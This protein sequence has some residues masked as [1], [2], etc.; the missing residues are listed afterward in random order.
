MG[1]N[2]TKGRERKDVIFS[3]KFQITKA[4]REPDGLE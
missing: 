3:C 1:L 2:V 4:K